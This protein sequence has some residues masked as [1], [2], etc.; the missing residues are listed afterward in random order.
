MTR[1]L[2]TAFALASLCACG[3]P[4]SGDS[5]LLGPDGGGT[6]LVDGGGDG[7]SDGGDAGVDG[8]PDAGCAAKSLSGL[9]SVDNCAG[10]VSAISS[11]NVGDPSQS[12]AVTITLTSNT[13]SCTGTASSGTKDAFEGTCTGIPGYAC[14]SP[15][16][17]GT[18][19]CTFGPSSCTIRICDGGTCAP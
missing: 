10:G 18:L 8:G 15:S 17:P 2:F 4:T 6:G 16:L 13:G 3:G 12:C 14:A 7:G 11:V 1:S 9:A 5:N 19:T